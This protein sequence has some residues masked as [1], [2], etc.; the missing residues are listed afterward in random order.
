MSPYPNLEKLEIGCVQYL[1]AR[2]LIFGY[3]G[4]VRFGH[5][6]QLAASLAEGCLDI[7]LVPVYELMRLPD[8]DIVDGVSIS[9]IGAVFSVFLAYKG[10][11]E[12]IKRICLDP[13]SLTSTHLLR[14]ILSEFHGLSPEYL[15]SD[16]PMDSEAGR[17]LI[18]NQAI[19]F[20]RTSGEEYNYLDLGGEWLEHTGLPFVF[21]VWLMRRNIADALAAANELR[22]LKQHGISSIPEIIRSETRYDAAFGNDYLRNHIHYNLG[23]AEKAGMEKFRELLIEHGFIPD[24]KPPFVFI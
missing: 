1:N 13:A 12:K 10:D 8:Y 21:A 15:S 14:C 22:V 24:C 5:P 20:R 16:N 17:L 4:K 7:A 23:G 18:G 19:D 9:S 11:L 3:A 6:S 2:P